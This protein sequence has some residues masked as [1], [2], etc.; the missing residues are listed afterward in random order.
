M[1]ISHHVPGED[2]F[3]T[4]HHG[5]IKMGNCSKIRLVFDASCKDAYSRSLN[6]LTHG[7]C[8]ARLKSP[9]TKSA[10]PLAAT[11]QREMLLLEHRHRRSRI[12]ALPCHE[13]VSKTRISQET[14]LSVEDACTLN[15]YILCRWRNCWDQQRAKG[16]LH[17]ENNWSICYK[18]DNCGRSVVASCGNL[19]PLVFFAFF[20]VYGVWV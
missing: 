4:P 3:C 17:Y 15:I 10:N 8:A 11:S 1:T 2:S 6:V 9:T 12:F 13:C 7:R 14:S 5:A 20:K 19:I 18:Q 16:S